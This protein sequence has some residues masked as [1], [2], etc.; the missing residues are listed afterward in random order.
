[1]SELDDIL[2]EPKETPD[3]PETTEPA[4]PTE[5]EKQE[6]VRSARREHQ[7]KEFSA[8]GLKRDPETG[9]FVSAKEE[10]KEPKE[11][12][13]EEPAKEAKE[14]AKEAPKE[15]PKEQ[16]KEELTPKERAFLQAAHEER[17]KRQ[18]LERQLAELQAKAKPEEPAKGFWDDPE[19]VLSKHEQQL[20]DVERNTI[21]RTSEMIAR[22][23]Y[24]DFDQEVGVFAEM[25]K[26]V[27]GLHQAWL[28]APDPAE[29]AYR[30]GKSHRQLSE[31]GGVDK[32]REKI[33]AETRAKVES[34]FRAKEEA[35]Q[36][37]M[38]ALRA[39]LPQSLSDARG[40]TQHRPVWTG[41]APLED[42][43]KN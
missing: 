6:Q 23:K 13:A 20:R 28:A 5:P 27:P 34:E 4:E 40:T 24:Q 12:K 32:L 31:A 37:E 36:K 14:P 8:R 26:A 42:I 1:M 30:T 10:P 3:K 21:L 35:R 43:L 18:N 19:G 16:P 17:V 29:F 22:S 38:A 33:E 9:Q 39:A 7:D 41:P 25:L 15:T 2:S 11:E